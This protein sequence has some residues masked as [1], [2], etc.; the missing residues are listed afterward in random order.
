MIK[1]TTNG[2]GKHPNSII[3]V[4]LK[5]INRKARV[6]IMAEADGILRKV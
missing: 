1:E 6:E 4:I 2:L 5:V 3:R